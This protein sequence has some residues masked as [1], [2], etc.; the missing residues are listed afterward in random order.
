MLRHA[1][2]RDEGGATVLHLATAGSSVRKHVGVTSQTLQL[3]RTEALA[4]REV[5]DKAFKASE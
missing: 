3:D 1:V 4:L 5:I 2:V